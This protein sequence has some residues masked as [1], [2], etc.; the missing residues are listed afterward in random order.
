VHDAPG[1]RAK[2]VSFAESCLTKQLSKR[3]LSD[4]DPRRRR[5]YF[6]IGDRSKNWGPT[7]RGPTTDVWT[8]SN[9]VVENKDDSCMTQPELLKAMKDITNKDDDSEPS[10]R[11]SFIENLLKLETEEEFNERGDGNG[12]PALDSFGSSCDEADN[13]GEALDADDRNIGISDRKQTH[14]DEF[15]TDS[16]SVS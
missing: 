12:T 11:L 10:G 7:G 2:L 4:G 9:Y 8:F 15:G 5:N 3:P 13:K 1:Q 6:T 16:I 14:N